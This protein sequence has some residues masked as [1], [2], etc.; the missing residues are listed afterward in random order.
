[1]KNF[2]KINNI[3]KLRELS[4]IEFVKQ[5]NFIFHAIL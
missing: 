4:I 5:Q 2:K 1:M 3:N